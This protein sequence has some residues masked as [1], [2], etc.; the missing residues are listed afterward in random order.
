[1]ISRFINQC[2]VPEPTLEHSFATEKE[3]ETDVIMLDCT[4]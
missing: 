4:I 1:M 3:R 2:Q